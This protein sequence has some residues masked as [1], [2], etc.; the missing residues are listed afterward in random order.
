MIHHDSE[1]WL[2]CYGSIISGLF[3]IYS[4]IGYFLSYKLSNK[5]EKIVK[6]KCMGQF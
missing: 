4:Y 2:L 1:T 3:T 5:W 6:A